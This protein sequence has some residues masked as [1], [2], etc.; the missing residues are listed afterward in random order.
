MGLAHKYTWQDFL[1][2]H[3]DLKQKKVKRNS[4]E[5][6]KAYKAAFKVFA[7]NYLK[8]RTANIEKEKERAAKSKTALVERLKAVDGK[9]WHLK[10]KDLNEKIGRFD[11]YLARLGRWQESTK[12]LA[13][14]V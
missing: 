12:E 7:K 6:D 14:K 2:A 13:K 3:P 5:G 11:S 1:K 10:A 8:E 4:P 9:K